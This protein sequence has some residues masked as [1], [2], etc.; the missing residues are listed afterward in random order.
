VCDMPAT[1]QQV[2]ALTALIQCMVQTISE[3]IDE[4]TYQ[5]DYHPMMVEQN[6]WRAARFGTDARLV[7]S[8]NFKQYSVQESVD[9]LIEL[10]I[11]MAERLDCVEELQSA[12][13]L[14]STTGSKQQLEIYK[15]TGSLQEV[16]R[17]MLEQNDWR[18][19]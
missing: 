6:K 4:G 12:S 7:D 19:G 8:R 11:P 3:E 9:S 13:R 10:L 16:V 17:Q 2:Q 14:P 15:N 1:L 18:K 5:S